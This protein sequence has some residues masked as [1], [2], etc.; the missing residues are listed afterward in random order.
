MGSGIPSSAIRG[1]RSTIGSQPRF[2]LGQG[3][4]AVAELVLHSLSQL[5][6]GLV[7]ARRHEQRIVTEAAL[8]SWRHVKV[9]VAHA[10]EHAGLGGGRGR[11][12]LDQRQHTAKPRRALRSRRGSQQAEHF[13]VVVRVGRVAGVPSGVAPLAGAASSAAKRAECTP[14]A[15]PS[16]STSKPESSAST[17]SRGF[18]VHPCAG[19]RC[20]SQRARTVAFLVALPAKSGASSTTGGASGKST[21]ERYS[22][23]SARMDRISC[24]LCGLRVAIKRMVMGRGDEGTKRLGW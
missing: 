10:F 19:R 7:I 6:E 9:A 3:A 2:Q 16:A 14:G 11:I 17:K 5:G 8:P 24:T 4:C 22:N 21:R 15:P 20:C 1:R 18:G 13:G 23:G 12:H